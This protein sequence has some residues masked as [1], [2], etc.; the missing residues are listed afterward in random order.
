[1]SAILVLL[2]PFAAAKLAS[3]SAAVIKPHGLDVK[4]HAL[5]LRDRGF[6]VVPDCVVHDSAL[7]HAASEACKEMLSANLNDVHNLGV[8]PVEQG[9]SFSEICH[10]SR[11][12]YDYRFD[13]DATSQVASATSA[14]ATSI[15]RTLYSLPPARKDGRQ[16][17]P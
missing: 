1:M 3:S 8:E 11:L 9:W 5:E 13:S 14:V 12:R 10:R 4:R 17:W 7:L 6:T 15:I 2:V 16:L